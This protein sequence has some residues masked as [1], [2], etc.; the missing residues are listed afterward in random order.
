MMTGVSTGILTAAGKLT[1]I[2]DKNKAP[3]G[4]FFNFKVKTMVK[5]YRA[6]K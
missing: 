1:A 4:A 6:F 2:N 3:K 5:N